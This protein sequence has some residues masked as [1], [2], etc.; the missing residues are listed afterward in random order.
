MKD[1]VAN[2]IGAFS[3]E[4]LHNLNLNIFVHHAPSER[5]AMLGLK[6]DH[7]PDTLKVFKGVDLST[8][9]AVSSIRDDHSTINPQSKLLPRTAIKARPL[10]MVM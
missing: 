2:S 7:R 5:L 8:C 10:V 1:A 4:L 9:P 3:A 6:A